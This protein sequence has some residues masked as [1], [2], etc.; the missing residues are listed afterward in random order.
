MTA[1]LAIILVC[2]AVLVGG[3]ATFIHQQRRDAAQAERAKQEKANAQFLELVRKG[4]S[5]YDACDRTGGV[6]DF[7]KGTCQRAPTE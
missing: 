1:R 5:V 4:A 7:R 2:V 6:Y 3:F